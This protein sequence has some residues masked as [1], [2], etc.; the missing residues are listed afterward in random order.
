MPGRLHRSRRQAA[1][2]STLSGALDTS[3]AITVL[4]G[5]NPGTYS[6]QTCSRDP[7]GAYW[8]SRAR[9][10]MTAPMREQSPRLRSAEVES[11]GSINEIQSIRDRAGA[12]LTAC[13]S[14]ALMNRKSTRADQPRAGDQPRHRRSRWRDATQ[15]AS[16]ARWP[17]R[18]SVE[19]EAVFPAGNELTIRYHAVGHNEGSRVGR[20]L[21]MGMAGGSK[22]SEADFVAADGTRVG[23]VR[24]EG[25]VGV[26][27]AGGSAK[28]G[29]MAP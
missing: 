4:T 7:M 27:I 22:P 18:S 9:A 19:P 5:P 15:S 13:S 29:L 8:E 26:G 24:A 6:L 28:S 21:T 20:Y 2:A 11:G 17:K 14:S 16:S 1:R 25:A 3:A 12:C 23:Q 10:T